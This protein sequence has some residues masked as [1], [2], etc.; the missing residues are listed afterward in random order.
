MSYLEEAIDL[1]LTQ[2]SLAEKINE[3]HALKGRSSN[4]SQQNV[5]YWIKTSVVPDIHCIAIS[6]ATEWKISPNK[7]RPDIYPHPH[8]GLPEEMRPAA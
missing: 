1:C 2:A 4:V 8:D 5:S 7:L 6:W 3:W